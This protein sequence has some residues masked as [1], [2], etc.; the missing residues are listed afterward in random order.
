MEDFDFKVQQVVKELER[1][2]PDIDEEVDA[3]FAERIQEM[4]NN[5]AGVWGN[6][7]AT[8]LDNNAPEIARGNINQIARNFQE[9]QTQLDDEVKVFRDEKVNF[10]ANFL[11][12][13]Y[14]ED[15]TD[16]EKSAI[17]DAVQNTLQQLE[18]EQN[19]VIG[20]DE[21]DFFD[22]D[23]FAYVEGS[24]ME[25]SLSETFSD[26]ASPDPPYLPSGGGGFEV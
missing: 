10:R 20:T 16:V 2:Q 4:D 9:Q 13:Q 26:A 19:S 3:E 1:M 25:S 15:A 24:E 11:I 8:N 23:D 12:D 6:V 22:A 5:Q 14:Y 18:Q 17:F 21:K 7:Q